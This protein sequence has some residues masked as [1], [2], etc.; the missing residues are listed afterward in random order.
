MASWV[1]FYLGGLRLSPRWSADRVSNNT[2]PLFNWHPL[3]ITLAF[4]ILMGEAVLA[5]RMPLLRFE[6]R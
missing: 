5:Y 3:L 1:F 4:P 2:G 6:D